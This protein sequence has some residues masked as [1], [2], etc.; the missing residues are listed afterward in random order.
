[1]KGTNIRRGAGSS[2]SLAPQ[3]STATR[4]GA[5]VDL[6]GYLSAIL[7]I[8]VGVI[9][10]GTHTPSLQESDDNST[11]TNVAAGD[12]EGSFAN[13]ASAT[14]QIVGYKGRKRFIRPVITVSGAT[15]GGVYGAALLRGG[16][17]QEP[18]A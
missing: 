6:A 4:N 5:S 17:Q 2:Q 11:W 16:A 12:L 7:V 3:A 14:Q 8:L 9:T 18:A 15:T 13:L 10:D 1:M